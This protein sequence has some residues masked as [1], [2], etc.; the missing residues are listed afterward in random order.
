V[1]ALLWIPY[2]VHSIEQDIPPTGHALMD[3]GITMVNLMRR[4]IG[5]H[6]LSAEVYI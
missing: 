4:G 3:A 2:T 1:C 5:G 6:T